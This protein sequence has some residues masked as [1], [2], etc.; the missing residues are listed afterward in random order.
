MLSS[1]QQQLCAEGSGLA[2][3]P[4]SPGLGPALFVDRSQL[5]LDDRQPGRVHHLGLPIAVGELQRAVPLPLCLAHHHVGGVVLHLCRHSAQQRRKKRRVWVRD[6][7]FWMWDFLALVEVSGSR[8]ASMRALR[9]GSLVTS[10][11]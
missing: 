9:D 1:F 11:S 3:S 2:A 10:S 7:H 5:L 8:I 6:V 4:R